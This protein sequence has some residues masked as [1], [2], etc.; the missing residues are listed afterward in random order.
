MEEDAAAGPDGEKR[1]RIA[2]EGVSSVEFE[3]LVQRID[4]QSMMLEVRRHTCLR[5]R[6]HVYIR[7]HDTI[8]Q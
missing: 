4:R 6:A 1:R 2:P 7:T 5:A 3:H 8:I